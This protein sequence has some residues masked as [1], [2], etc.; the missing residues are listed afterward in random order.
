MF[1]ENPAILTHS[2]NIV[3]AEALRL[4]E[5]MKRGVSQT[6]RFKVGVS[7][8]SLSADFYQTRFQNHFFPD[9]DI[10][11]LKIVIRNFDGTTYSMECR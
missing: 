9:Y 8:G 10:N 7:A 5:A 2:R 11:P 6:W 1:S 4:E 3:F